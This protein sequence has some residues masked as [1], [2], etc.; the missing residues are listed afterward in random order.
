MNVS[1]SFTKFLLVVIIAYIAI[2][3]KNKASKTSSLLSPSDTL[4]LSPASYHAIQF[5]GG[6]I[7]FW[8]QA[9][10]AKFILEHC[11]IDDMHLIGGSAGSI[12]TALLLAK[13][14]F[15]KAA[16]IAVEEVEKVGAHGSISGLFG[17]W[18]DLLQSFLERLIVEEIEPSPVNKKDYSRIHIAVT[19]WN[20]FP[21]PQYL[22][23]ITSKSDLIE[24]VLISTHIPFFM[25]G[26]PWRI[27]RDGFYYLDGSLW[28]FLFNFP[29]P[30]PS[31][32]LE[33]MQQQIEESSSDV[34]VTTMPITDE[35]GEQHKVS[36]L[37]ID[38]RHDKSFLAKTNNLHI[39]KL[40]SPE[41]LYDMMNDGYYYMINEYYKKDKNLQS[42]CHY[43]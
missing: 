20:I 21:G 37:I 40:I 10:V 13:A 22:A 29:L 14:D 6:G 42:F 36:V 32:L 3:F 12:T 18:S 39:V 16:Q 24:A 26:K 33:K 4:T 34:K 1:T 35:K 31:L 25:N 8:W 27:A 28:S 30:I 41:T 5:N 19:P 17:I 2:I 43:E 9:G 38:H 15:N 7:F 23:N 11:D